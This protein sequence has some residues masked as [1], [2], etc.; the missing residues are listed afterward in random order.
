MEEDHVLWC[1]DGAESS[2]VQDL[3]RMVCAT[4]GLSRVKEQGMSLGASR[5]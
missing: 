1:N 4:I 2:L 3:A 5:R